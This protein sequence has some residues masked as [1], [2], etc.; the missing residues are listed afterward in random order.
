MKHKLTGASLLRAKKSLRNRISLR[1]WTIIALALFMVFAIGVSALQ[2]PVQSNQTGGRNAGV[3]PKRT[4][5]RRNRRDSKT[6]AL[7]NTSANSS[8]LSPILAT[9]DFDL[10]GLAVTADPATLTVPKNTSTSI[11]TSVRVPEGTDPLSII[12]ALNPNYRVRGELTGPSLT[13]PLTLEAPIGQPLNIPAL[14][15]A[16]DHLVR[17]LRVVDLS[18]PEQTVVTSVTPDSV[19][20]VVI[21]RLLVSQ[22][23]VHELNYDQIVQAGINI[24]GDSYR[25]FNFT[26]GIATTSIAQ[27][28]TIPVASSHSCATTE[29]STPY[30]RRPGNRL[31]TRKSPTAASAVGPPIK[32]PAQPSHAGY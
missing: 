25:A 23:Q 26:L 9:A 10:L 21:E 24:T 2:I 15:N 22:V 20:I 16:G 17:N 6:K 1:T 31:G 19:G 32:I 13:A 18:T 12:T 29:P 28:I 30:S 14:S 7:L 27:N 11:H 8:I 4:T 5:E 3:K